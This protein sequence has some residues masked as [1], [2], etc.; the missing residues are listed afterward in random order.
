LI[1]RTGRCITINFAFDIDEVI[2][3]TIQTILPLYNQKYR[4]SLQY[5]DLID[6]DMKNFIDAQ[7]T[8]IF[9]EFL[10][11]SLVNSIKIDDATLDVIE[12]VAKRHTVFFA[13]ARH[14]YVM[15]ATDDWLGSQVKGYQSRSLIRC[16]EKSLLLFD[17]IVD[18]HIMNL[19]GGRFALKILPT[20]PWN[21]DYAVKPYNIKRIFDLTEVPKIIRDF[22]KRI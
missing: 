15:K 11:E 22:E 12:E 6:Y 20:K 2:S 7:C 13:T 8:N 1:R 10:T 3:P 4:K 18:D 19:I 16:A 17:G 21:S 5:E 14:P 9:E